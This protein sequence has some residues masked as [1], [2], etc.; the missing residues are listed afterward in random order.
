MSALVE[1]LYPAPVERRTPLAVIGWW[2]SRRWLY[3][4]VVGAAGVFTLGA[5]NLL[6]LLPGGP[7]PMPLEAM[8]VAPL[9]YGT[10]ANLCYSSGWALE[11]LAKAA[12][13]NRAPHMG[14]LL[15]R[16]GLIFSVGLTLLPVPVFLVVSTLVSLGILT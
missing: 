5:I 7:P 16:E 11:L 14:P 8:V 10:A 13:G 4:R 1:I 2:E 6:A 12:W 15:F 9:A 3:N